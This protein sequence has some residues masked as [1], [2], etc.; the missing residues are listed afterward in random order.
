MHIFS[1]NSVGKIYDMRKATYENRKKHNQK[2]KGVGKL[3]L[4]CAL[5]LPSVFS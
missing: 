5:Q 3:K 4:T 2:I 1:G